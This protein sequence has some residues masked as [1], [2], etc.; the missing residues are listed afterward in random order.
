MSPPYMTN[1]IYKPGSKLLSSCM[2][3]LNSRFVISSAF[4]L[5]YFMYLSYT[6]RT[7][8]THGTSKHE[9][10]TSGLRDVP[11]CPMANIHISKDRSRF[12][13]S[14]TICAKTRRNC[15][16]DVNSHCVCFFQGFQDVL[17]MQLCRAIA[18]IYTY[19]SEVTVSHSEYGPIMIS[20]CVLVLSL[21]IQY[22]DCTFN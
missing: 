9:I 20:D 16:E 4:I 17:H 22:Q 2:K 1:T 8:A 6:T 11:L 12:R 21:P 10:K 7:L 15:M 14:R 18:P 19:M 5:L 13:T 3:C